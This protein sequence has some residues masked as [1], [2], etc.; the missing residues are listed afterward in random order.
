MNYNIINII[1]ALFISVACITLSYN[2]AFTD[3][4]DWKLSET[5]RKTLIAILLTYTV[6]R[7]FR[8]YKL[9]KK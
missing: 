7:L 8:V 1:L 4:I 9:L 2:L 6:F 5:M 3:T